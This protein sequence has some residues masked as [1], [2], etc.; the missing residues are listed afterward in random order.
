MDI[1]HAQDEV[2]AILAG[3]IEDYYLAGGTALAK[4]YF[5]HRKSDDLDFFTKKFDINRINEI[6]ALL[7]NVS[8]KKP[9]MTT[10]QA[11]EGF[12]KIAVFNIGFAPD[13]FLKIDFVEDNIALLKPLKKINGIDVMSVEDIYVR[14]IYA[15]VGMIS[16]KDETGRTVLLGGRSEVKDFFDLYFLSTA[17]MPISVFA[18]R[19]GDS[20]VKEGLVRW[21]RTYDRTDIKAGL[22]D[23]K[24]D[25]TVT[26]ADMEKH[27]KLEIDKIL[28]TEIKF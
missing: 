17:F 10:I 28:E 14:K 3:K 5:H 11:K 27:F 8:G 15:S 2:L 23:I 18:D 25:S 19:Y 12:A 1:E 13:S 7:S 9:E 22:L 20:T 4:Y 24:T 26:Y 16:K 21:F 6:M